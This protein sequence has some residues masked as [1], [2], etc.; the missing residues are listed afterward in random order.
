[1]KTLINSKLEEGFSPEQISGWAKREGINMVSHE[2]IY[3]YIWEDKHNNG[4]LYTYL[5]RR[6]RKN[7]KRANERNNRGNIK[8]RVDISERD[9]IKDRVDISERDKIVEQKTRLGDLEIDTVI[10]KNHKSVI[11]TINDRV[12]GYVWIKKLKSKNAKQLALKK[13]N[14]SSQTL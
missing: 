11:L 7:K 13:N 6:G 5:R 14:S 9:K 2:T 12:S 3:L 8:D 10:G 1:M 4:N